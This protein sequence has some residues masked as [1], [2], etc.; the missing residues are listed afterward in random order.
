MLACLHKITGAE[1]LIRARA[2]VARHPHFQH[3]AS[4][5]PDEKRLSAVLDWPGVETLLLLDSFDLPS[6]EEWMPMHSPCGLCAT[7]G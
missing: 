2:A 4:P 6:G 3:Y 1:L 7:R 5:F